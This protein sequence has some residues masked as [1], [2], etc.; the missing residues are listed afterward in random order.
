MPSARSPKPGAMI[1]P[2]WAIS[3]SATSASVVSSERRDRRGVLQRQARHAHRVDDALLD[4]VAELAG[5]RVQPVAGRRGQHLVDRGLAVIARVRGDPIQRLREHGT[6][7]LAPRALVAGER[8]PVQSRRR[9]QQRRTAT[10]DHPL[11]HRRLRRGQRALGAPEALLEGRLG[12][13]RR[14]GS[15][16]GSRTAA[17]SAPAGSRRRARAPRGPARHCELREP[18]RRRPRGRRHLLDERAVVR[19]SRRRG[20]RC[21]SARPRRPRATSPA[22]SRRSRV[23]PQ[24]AARSPRCWM[25]RCAEAG[26]AHGHGLRRSRSSCCARACRARWPRRSRTGSRS[27][28]RAHGPPR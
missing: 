22:S 16:P 1:A 19:G 12:R 2:G 27:A 10:R 6:D 18:A 8:E 23:P 17:R 15:R 9:P 21:R 28:G 3:S 13:A 20:A 25:R 14:R 11:G 24:N 26:R 7:D 5:Q 4:E